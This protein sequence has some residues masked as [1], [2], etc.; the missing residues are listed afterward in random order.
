MIAGLYIVA[1]NGMK[2]LPLSPWQ[3]LGVLALWAFGAVTLGTL[4]LRFRDA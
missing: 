2:S 1:T 4:F 3:G